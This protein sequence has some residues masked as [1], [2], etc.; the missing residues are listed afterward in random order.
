MK[1]NWVFWVI[2]DTDSVSVFRIGPEGMGSWDSTV[3]MFGPNLTVITGD[4]CVR[5]N[6]VIANKPLDWFRRELGPDCLAQKFLERGYQEDRAESLLKDYLKEYA[7]ELKDDPSA[8]ANGTYQE[9]REEFKELRETEF[10]AEEVYSFLWRHWEGE[11]VEFTHHY[12][13]NEMR[14]LSELQKRF[15]T[16]YNEYATMDP[17]PEAFMRE[18]E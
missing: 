14:R 3:Y 6:G 2:E 18:L 16:M 11:G 4:L 7:Q 1:R 8:S 15:A 13:R 10:P 9:M 5:H 17:K 12:D